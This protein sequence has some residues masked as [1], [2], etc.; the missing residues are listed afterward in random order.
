MRANGRAI[1]PAGRRSQC[2]LV[3]GMPPPRSAAKVAPRDSASTL[4]SVG[5]P[6]FPTGAKEPG[7]PGSTMKGF[8]WATV[9]YV[10]EFGITIP[11][12]I[13]PVSEWGLVT[14][15]LFVLTAGTLVL[16]RRRRI[17]RVVG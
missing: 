7:P 4:A 16:T 8:V 2:P 12:D 15:A 10:A 3:A 5:L 11:P 9:D 17:S 13:P 6:T 14:M 1:R